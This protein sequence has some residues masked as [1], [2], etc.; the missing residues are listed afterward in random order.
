M[1]ELADGVFC[2]LSLLFISPFGMSAKSHHAIFPA[3]NS[4]QQMEDLQ[5]T[6]Y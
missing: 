1:I 3:Q 4:A 5:Q 6:L 2:T